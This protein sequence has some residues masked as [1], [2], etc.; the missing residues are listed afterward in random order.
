[1][2]PTSLQ[3][4]VRVTR[5]A[6]VATVVAVV[7]ALTGFE[8]AA[9][10]HLPAADGWHAATPNGP[11]ARDEGLSSCSICRLAHETASGPVTPGTVS[12][13]LPMFVERVSDLS[14][15]PF[16]VLASENSPRAP[17]CL[18]SC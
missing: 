15:L 14:A 9:H 18:A 6:V 13:P 17:P 1:M 7:V 4:P 3:L 16:E 2:R 5:L 12:S 11:T 10:V 8:A